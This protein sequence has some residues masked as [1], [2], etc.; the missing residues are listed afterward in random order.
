VGVRSAFRKLTTPVEELDRERRREQCVLAGATPCV[1]VTPRALARVAGEVSSVRIVP[2]SGAPSL[3]VSINDGYG[4]ATA[5]FLG[6]RHLA[7]LSPGRRVA[8]E[9][10]VQADP[11]RI[12][13]VNPVYE[14]G[15]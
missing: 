4:R 10:R 11:N 15:A 9:G 7:G 8:F 12:V 2:R 3:E 13:L 5:I 1:E 14:L 6:R